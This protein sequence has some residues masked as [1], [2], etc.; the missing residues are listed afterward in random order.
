[1]IGKAIAHYKV[2]A[3]LGGGGMG[4]VYL[5]E[6][7]TLGRQVALKF[8]PEQLSRDKLA[9]ERFLREARAA[10]ALNHPNICTVYE[11]GEYEG[12]RFMAM[13]LL[14]GQTLKQRIAGRPLPS[15]M[16]L[17]WA[18]EVADALDAAHTGGIV[19]RDIK[20][21]NIFIT[22]RGHAKVLDFGLAKLTESIADDEATL[23]AAHLT[24]PGTAVGTIAYM[25]PEQARGEVVDARTDIFSLGAVLYEM[26]TGRLPFEGN[27]TALIHDAILNRAPTAAVR[28][29]P[30]LPDELGRIIE[31]A[32]E[33]DRELRYQSMRELRA[34]LKRLLRDTSSGRSAAARP[35]A[36]GSAAAP[37]ATAKELSSDSVIASDL[38]KRHKK[39][40]LVIVGGMV[41]LLGVAGY[42]LY[43]LLGPSAGGAPIDSIVVLPFENVGGNLDS[44]YLSDGITENLINS[45]SQVSRL[46]V[47]PRTTA[48]HYKGQKADPEQIGKE[49]NVSAIVTGRVTQRGD[50]F[51]VSVELTDVAR[52]S[53]LW[54]EQYTQKMAD[55]LAVQEKMSRAI[56]QN[57][58]LQLTSSEQQKLSK[59]QTENA[60]AYELYLKARYHSAKLTEDGIQKGFEYLRQ[61]IEKDPTYALAYAGLADSYLDT[62]DLTLPPQEAWPKAK[63]AAEKALQLDPSLASARATLGV[64][65]F[66]YE[67]DWAGAESD[68][69]EAIRLQPDHVRA[70][71][72]YSWYLVCVGRNSEAREEAK[73]A[74]K[75]DPLSA[76]AISWGGVVSYYARKYDEAVEQEKRTLEIDPNYWIAHYA[77]GWI[78]LQKGQTREAIAPL[79]KATELS[80]FSMAIAP[81]GY[82]HAK[83]GNRPEAMKLLA[84]LK[85]RSKTG[86]VAP[87]DMALLYFGLG[88]KEQGYVWLEKALEAR[89]WWIPFIKAEPWMDPLRSEPRFQALIRR[90]NLPE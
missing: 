2:T 48:F 55:V 8:L 13:E 46:R 52:Q 5:G 60:E 83:A 53:Q 81:L 66:M 62:V 6:D 54:G 39:K 23:G 71:S 89:S 18:I 10:A 25:S 75:I 70:H 50:S 29:N 3:K 67:L 45:L 77:L 65:K 88:D 32:L 12:E 36:A 24:S 7:T 78:Y 11:I 64:V 47:V 17:E 73:R 26:A 1:M 9:L 63:E 58:K 51:V 57:L 87:Y 79:Q 38:V 28:V 41:L 82:A 31:R 16:L 72:I 85:E 40:L 69:K 42:G 37:P 43:R 49:L 84:K 30:D 56:T 22:E 74:Q 14:K 86:I 80:G 59:K 61:A 90:M 33:K 44:E 35:A 20:P 21:G 76:E 15:D 27:S 4:V 68:L 34:E 19:H